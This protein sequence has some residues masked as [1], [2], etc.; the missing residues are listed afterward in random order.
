MGCKIKES[1]LGPSTYVGRGSRVESSL[2]LG[3]G[4]WMSDAQRKEALAAGQRVY[5][6]GERGQGSGG[7]GVWMRA[8]SGPQCPALCCGLWP[9]PE[10]LRLTPPAPP[11]T[12]APLTTGENCFLR[13]CVVDENASIGNNVQVGGWGTP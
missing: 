5:G 1:V 13:R 9:R 4:A 3:N 8:R 11:S 6:V 12:P 10:P 7:L 2:L